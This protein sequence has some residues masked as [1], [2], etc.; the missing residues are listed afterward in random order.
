MSDHRNVR[1]EGVVTYHAGGQ[2]N[3]KYALAINGKGDDQHVAGIITGEPNDL[4]QMTTHGDARLTL[5]DGQTIA[6]NLGGVP[7][8]KDSVEFTTTEHVHALN[9]K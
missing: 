9:A 6:I 4:I 2:I 3:V 1:G 7:I 8:G 5:E